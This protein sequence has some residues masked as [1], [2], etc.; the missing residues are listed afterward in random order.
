MKSLIVCLLA[1]AVLGGCSSTNEKAITARDYDAVRIIH[2]YVAKHQRWTEKEYRI[3]RD[4]T[5]GRFIIYTAIN[6]RDEEPGVAPGGGESFEVFY[7]P[8]GH[9]IVK[10]L[11]FE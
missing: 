6:L 3:E 5:E 2:E 9:K 10:E 4:R 8:R 7:D 11:H 1:V